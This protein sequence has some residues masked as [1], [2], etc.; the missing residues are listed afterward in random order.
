MKQLGGLIGFIIAVVAIF[1][2]NSAYVVDETKQVILTQ[3]GK[4]VTKPITDAGLHF[5]T[6]FLQKANYF[7]KRVLEW[8]G[9]PTEVPTRDKKFIWI[10]T[11]GRW[12][13]E[14]P[15]LFMRSMGTETNAQS[16]LDGI[17]DGAIRDTL[18]GADLHE[19]I[20]NSDRQF[21]IDTEV[22]NI[23][24]EIRTIERGREQITRM[25]LEKARPVVADYGIR[26][27][28][29][30]I[31]RLNYVDR[32][33]RKVYERMI[34]ERT[35]AAEEMRSEGFGVRAEV[36][37]Q[38]ER[39]L[40]RIESEAY[41]SSQTIIGKADAEAMHIYADAYSLD[42]EFYSFM[43]SLELY[44]DALKGSQIILSSNGDFLKYLSQMKP[45]D[46]KK[47]L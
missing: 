36:E 9:R 1:A 27:L 40:K 41:R 8:D 15:L 45:E 29:M 24:Q 23:T 14:D 25:I 43:K 22:N 16:R 18:T 5:K 3:F 42:P 6:P 37:G 32:V 28:D 35:R 7:E 20:R 31:K 17:L 33:R 34:S 46:V 13:I 47:V 12:Q 19:I 2:F 44:P 21:E 39:E 4:P 11:T 26:L 38:K 10:D 30:R